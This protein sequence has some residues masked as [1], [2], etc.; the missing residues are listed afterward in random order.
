MVMSSYAQTS[1]TYSLNTTFKAFD[2]GLTGSTDDIYID[3]PAA[4]IKSDATDKVSVTYTPPGAGTYTIQFFVKTDQDNMSSGRKN[5]LYV[6][7][8]YVADVAYDS[9]A[10]QAVGQTATLTSGSNT[11]ELRKSWGFTHVGYVAVLDGSTELKRFYVDDADF[12]YSGTTI[13]LRNTSPDDRWHVDFRQGAGTEERPNIIS[14]YTFD[15]PEAGEYR[16]SIDVNFNY[17]SEGQNRQQNLYVNDSFERTM[18]FNPANIGETFDKTSWFTFTF[19]NVKLNAGSNSIEIRENWGFM[20]ISDVKV[21]Q[22]EYNLSVSGA[23]GWRMMS[24]PVESATFDDLLSGLW[25]QGFTGADVAGGTSNV[26]VYNTTSGE[27]D[28]ISDQSSSLNSGSGFITYVYAKDDG[29]DGSG[30]FP[31]S[32]KTTGAEPNGDVSPTLNSSTSGWTLVGNPYHSAVDADDFAF[33]NVQQVVYTYNASTS[34]Y[35]S[36]NGSAGSLTDGIISPYQG[37]WVQNAASGTPTLTIPEAAKTTGTTFYK[38]TNPSQNIKII[39]SNAT[40]TAETWFSFTSEGE[41]GNDKS[42]ALLFR[43]LDHVDYLMIG[44]RGENGMLNINNLSSDLTQ[45]VKIPLS[46]RSLKAVQNDD[47]SG[48]EVISDGI[49]LSVENLNTL[50]DSWKVELL[51]KRTGKWYNLREDASLELQLDAA[52]AEKSAVYSTAL[53]SQEEETDSRFEVI[54]EPDLTVSNEQE[55]HNPVRSTLSQNYPNPFN[56]ATTI[57]YS[58]VDNGFVSVRVFNTLGQKV[59]EL[60]GSTKSAG[61]HAVTFNAQGLNS[62]VYFYQLWVNDQ[63][64]DSKALTIVK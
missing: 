4:Y 7:G 14:E 9:T 55:L 8:S 52:V 35:I 12:S 22:Q 51:D 38:E 20:H 48:Y 41:I 39:V 33:T 2:A 47:Q 5:D 50:P 16:L 54:I 29:P 45:T 58:L 59:R 57:Q 42:D 63:H 15:A 3:G 60:V 36:W 34:S 37:F 19:D 31:K 53:F 10:W 61:S 43:P 49:E 21:S 30:T 28:P 46:V 24:A 26:R 56:P 13:E 18:I 17:G 44:T 27:F 32:I 1:T 25:T 64:I 6:N 62:G 40:K 23:E 11:I